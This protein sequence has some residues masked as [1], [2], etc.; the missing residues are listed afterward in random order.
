MNSANLFKNASALSFATPPSPASTSS[1]RMTFTARC[2]SRTSL[3]SKLT[4]PATAATAS[5]PESTTKTSETGRLPASD[6]FRLKPGGSL[7]GSC[8]CAATVPLSTTLGGGAPS[9]GSPAG[10]TPSAGGSAGVSSKQHCVLYASQDSISA[11][12]TA[13]ALDLARSLPGAN[14]PIAGSL[15]TS[16]T[17]DLT[18]SLAL[19]A[20]APSSL[21][22]PRSA[23]LASSSSAAAS[24]T[25]S[26]QLVPS[27]ASANACASAKASRIF[28]AFAACLRHATSRAVALASSGEATFLAPVASAAA[29]GTCVAASSSRHARIRTL[30]WPASGAHDQRSAAVKAF[31]AA[32][33]C[34]ASTKPSP[35]TA[36]RLATCPRRMAISA[37]SLASVAAVCVPRSEAA[38]SSKAPASACRLKPWRHKT[39][40]SL[41]SSLTC[42]PT[43]GLCGFLASG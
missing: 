10:S 20:S 31:S 24:A 3:T 32:A 14:R 13:A 34:V 23:S 22:C 26:G 35:P 11:E 12:C 5:S 43:A 7:V 42:T 1:L 19:G 15:P 25:C 2:I 21:G 30:S 39:S 16:L 6:F 38:S 18:T 8:H 17:K 36:A 29:S 41:R 9:S 4:S 37:C 33:W 40:A 28:A 27:A